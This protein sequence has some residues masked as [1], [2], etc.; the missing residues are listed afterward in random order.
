MPGA[1]GGGMRRYTAC[2]A[3][4]RQAG[5]LEAGD[6]ISTRDQ[7]NHLVH[8]CEELLPPG[9]RGP[10]SA[11]ACGRRHGAMV[12]HKDQ[13]SLT[14]KEQE[15]AKSAFRSF[16]RDLSGTIDSKELKA[17]LNTLGQSPTDEDVF[18]M[19]AEVDSDESGE[20][21]VDEFLVVVSRAKEMM[22]RNDDSDTVAAFVAMGGAEDRS[23]EV[24]VEKLMAV[25]QDFELA[26]DLPSMLREVDKD[27]SGKIDF[28]EFKTL[29]SK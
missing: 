12:R 22:S 11:G 28:N 29:L 23:G 17:V 8:G 5:G 10:L 14:P 4:L 15:D 3:A 24:S 27:K 13:L 26:I 1:A 20:I 25:V 21:D 7:T 19:I 9:T 18:N 16:D 6:R 2:A